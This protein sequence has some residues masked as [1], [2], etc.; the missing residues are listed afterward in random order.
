MKSDR[1][2]LTVEYGKQ[3]GKEF[4]F[5]DPAQCTVGRSCD[6]NLTLPTDYDHVDVSRHHCVFEIVPPKVYVRDLGSRNG[7]FVNGEKIGQRPEHVLAEDAC[8]STSP[9]RELHDGD[10]VQIGKTVLRVGTSAVE[11]VADSEYVPLFSM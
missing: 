9:A 1:V 2:V 3:Q 7:T 4:V 11:H 6:C 8:Q 5:E 10:E